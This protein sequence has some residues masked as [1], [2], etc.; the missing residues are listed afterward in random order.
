MNP[1]RRASTLQSKGSVSPS[2][3]NYAPRSPVMT[4]NT[5]SATP[6]FAGRIV[7]TREAAKTLGC[8]MSLMRW[9]AKSGK[10]RAWALGPRSYGFDLDDCLRYKAE[11]DAVREAARREGRR[12]LG[13]EPQG[14]SPDRPGK[15][16]EA[17][18]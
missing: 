15:K 7:L 10:V 17:R 12:A 13:G 14:F 3:R 4:E 1:A 11:Q 5:I 6:P 18:V 16:R 8:S 2:K 9:L